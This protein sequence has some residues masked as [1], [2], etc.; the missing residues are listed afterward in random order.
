MHSMAD[1]NDVLARLGEN[2]HTIDRTTKSGAKKN[3][4]W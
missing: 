3:P 2:C 4:Y 1:L